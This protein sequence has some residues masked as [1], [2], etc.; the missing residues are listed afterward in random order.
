MALKKVALRRPEDG[1]PNTAL[2]EIKALQLLDGHDNIVLLR[3]VFAHGSG[4][5]LVF[6][7]MLSGAD[8]D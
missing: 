7:F 4:F 8:K 5:V 1:I 2:R 6:E 3:Q